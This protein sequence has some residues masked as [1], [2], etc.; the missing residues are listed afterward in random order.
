MNET[1]T[2]NPNIS[3]ASQAGG[4]RYAVNRSMSRARLSFLGSV[5]S[6]LVKLRSVASTWWL[7]ALACIIGVG[8]SAI[9][10]VSVKQEACYDAKGKLLA[11]PAP[12]PRSVVFSC[13]AQSL[14]ISIVLI[15]VVA[16]LAVTSEYATSSIQMA[17]VVN[18]RRWMFMNAKAVAVAI[19]TFVLSLVMLL[20]SWGVV[21]AILAGNKQTPLGSK[22]HWLPIIVILGG[23]AMITLV[24]EF[25]LGLGAIIRSTAGGVVALV[26]VYTMATSVFGLIFSLSKHMQWAYWCSQLM[27]SSLV[28]SFLSGQPAEVEA[29]MLPK[30]WS[31]P[32]WWQSGLIMLG[33]AVVFYLIGA[34][35]VRRRDVK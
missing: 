17:L 3:S 28:N 8:I 4:A 13:I 29:G 12:I 25:S 32:G 14:A 9:L 34:F 1:N 6:E 2:M 11:T 27:P 7:S 5:R 26:A 10:A 16:I 30:G 33:W 21:A 20:I 15:G 19:H 35:V 24:S 18:P 22:E 23:A 31:V